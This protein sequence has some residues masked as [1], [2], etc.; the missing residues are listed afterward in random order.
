MILRRFSTLVAVNDVDALCT[1]HQEIKRYQSEG[2]S[3]DQLWKVANGEVKYADFVRQRQEG[4]SAPTAQQAAGPPPPTLPRISDEL[5]SS[6]KAI[7]RLPS[8]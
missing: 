7:P 5:V 3:L 8:K 6:G 1:V 2:V 4:A